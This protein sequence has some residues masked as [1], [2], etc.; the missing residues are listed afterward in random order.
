MSQKRIIE[1]VVIS[2]AAYLVIQW[3]E[4]KKAASGATPASYSPGTAIQT[5]TNGVMV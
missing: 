4:K 3:Y 5:T 1:G 2:L